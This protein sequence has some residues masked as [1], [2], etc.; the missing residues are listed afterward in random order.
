MPSPRSKANLPDTGFRE[1]YARLEDRI[2]EFMRRAPGDAPE[3]E[4]NGLA[5]DIFKFQANRNRAYAAF[6]LALGKGR[7]RDPASWRE[8]PAVPTD[9][10]RI[11]AI[12]VAC[13]PPGV[14]ELCFETSGT[15]SE[16]PGRHYL[17]SDALCRRSIL[18]GWRK[19]DLPELPVAILVPSPGDA[20]NSSLSFMLGTLAGEFGPENDCYLVTR[21]GALDT[22]KI[23]KRCHADAPFLLLGTALAFLH[24]FESSGPAGDL[25]LPEGSWAMETGGYKG[26]KRRIAKTDLYALFDEHL[27]LPPGH[28]INEYG[29][30]ELSSQ[31]YATGL[32]TPHRGPHWTRA[33]FLDPESGCEVAPGE[34]GHLVITDL[35]NLGSAITIATRDLAV[36]TGNGDFSAGASFQLLG[37]DPEALPRGCSRAAD[38]LFSPSPPPSPRP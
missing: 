20:P 23:Q 6:C 18:Q 10:F 35:A 7:I 11:P 1:E 27:G 32:E 8:I 9:A 15:T 17:F 5:L 14:A 22:V 36:R 19:L 26:T 33:R 29:M 30:T 34:T 21:K 3:A 25:K 2:C 13:F 37:R 28:I 24:L 12:P 4:F 31:F 16:T 38:E